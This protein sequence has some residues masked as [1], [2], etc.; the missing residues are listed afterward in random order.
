MEQKQILGGS[1]TLKVFRKSDHKQV[2]F[3]KYA[4]DSDVADIYAKYDSMDY[5]II[6]YSN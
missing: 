1:Y 6:C 4:D 3:N 5:T 2:Y